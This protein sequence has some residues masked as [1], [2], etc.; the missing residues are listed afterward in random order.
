MLQVAG[1]LPIEQKFKISDLSNSMFAGVS[2]A[3]P[4][5]TIERTKIPDQALD[6]G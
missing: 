6:P 5:P 2:A 3:V 1:L 4:V